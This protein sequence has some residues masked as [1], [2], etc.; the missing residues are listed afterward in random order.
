MV[1]PSAESSPM[2][3]WFK[4][5]P[6]GPFQSSP[7]APDLLG[8]AVEGHHVQPVDPARVEVV[9]RLRLAGGRASDNRDRV[10][11]ALTAVLTTDAVG[12]RARDALD[13]IE[14]FITGRH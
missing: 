3:R 13:D 4:P 12:S 14:V 5:G 6:W 1:F 7:R 8:G 10:L 2:K 9:H 11:P